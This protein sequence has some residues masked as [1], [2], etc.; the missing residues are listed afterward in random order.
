MSATY[1][2]WWNIQLCS[3]WDLLSHMQCR[4]MSDALFI[5]LMTIITT[6]LNTVRTNV[7]FCKSHLSLLNVSHCIFAISKW[8]FIWITWLTRIEMR[9]LYLIYFLCQVKQ[10][11]N[12]IRSNIHYKCFF[13][14]W[15]HYSLMCLSVWSEWVY[16]IGMRRC[17]T[18]IHTYINNENAAR[19][20]LVPISWMWND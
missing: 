15:W 12:H 11:A 18:H 1:K 16:L 2:M 3:L 7:T 6:Q 5:L 8:V 10:A 4:S 17:T 13:F 19:Q 14:R 9:Y 20:R